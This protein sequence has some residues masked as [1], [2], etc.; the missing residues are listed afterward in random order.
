MTAEPSRARENAGGPT[1]DEIAAVLAAL[2]Q[3]GPGP[4]TSG[5]ERWRRTRLAARAAAGPDEA[6]RPHR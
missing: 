5:Y 2:A 1:P 4:A 6:F 3:C